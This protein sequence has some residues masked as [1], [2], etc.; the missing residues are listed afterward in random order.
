VSEARRFEALLLSMDAIHAEHDAVGDPV[1]TAS[2]LTRGFTVEAG[3]CLLVDPRTVETLLD[4][5]RQARGSLPLTWAAFRA[6]D[7]GWRSVE[8]VFRESVGLDQKHVAEFDQHAAG[9]VGSST[10]GRLA[11]ELSRLRERLQA[12]TAVERARCS[13]RARHVAVTPLRD[14]QAMLSI[15]GPSPAIASI[16]DGLTQTAVAAHGDP[17]EDRHLGALRHDVAVDLLLGGLQ[18]DPRPGEDLRVPQRKAV[19]ATCLIVLPAL[20]VLGKSAE[21]AE[22]AGYGPIDIET[23]MRHA[24]DAGYWTRV[25]TDPTTGGLTG[26]D[27]HAERIPTAW[28]RWLTLR[29]GTCRAPGCSHSAGTCDVDHTI[30]REHGGATALDNLSCLCRTHH[31]IKDDGCW[32]LTLHPDGTQE[33]RSIWATT[34]LTRPDVLVGRAAPPPTTPPPNSEP[35]DHDCPF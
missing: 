12:D 20:S 16:Y 8:T 2:V 10:T 14:G 21:P 3:A 7:C 30:R 19:T 6:G 5:A 4:R 27:A 9:L 31:Q 29:D 13:A 1:L 28:R 25:F 24:G 23:A 35:P 34:R 18:T 22:V 33:W 32:D 26:L 15:V 11:R 17:D